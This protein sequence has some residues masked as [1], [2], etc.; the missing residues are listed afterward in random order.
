MDD[1]LFVLHAGN[2]TDAISGKPPPCHVDKHG[3]PCCLYL[4][5]NFG[6][7]LLITIDPNTGCGTF[8]SGKMGWERSYKLVAGG[9]ESLGLGITEA[10]IFRYFWEWATGKPATTP[11]VSCVISARSPGIGTQEAFEN[12]IV[13][14]KALRA[15]T[16]VIF[17]PE[18]LGDTHDRCMANLQLLADANLNLRLLNQTEIDEMCGNP[19]FPEESL[20]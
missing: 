4:G 14:A 5:G 20:N 3:G 17:K 6:E 2:Q 12:A 7:Q 1:E 18:T 10:Q 11:W 13:K 8:R 9:I 19:Q 15:H 16:I